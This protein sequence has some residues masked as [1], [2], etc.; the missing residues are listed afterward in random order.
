M[1][2]PI[3]SGEIDR[4]EKT[5]SKLI[6]GPISPVNAGAVLPVCLFKDDDNQWC[7]STTAPMLK[8]GW[9]WQQDAATGW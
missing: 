5:H 8:G 7:I 1:P 9:N 6:R 2:A 3:R 4:V